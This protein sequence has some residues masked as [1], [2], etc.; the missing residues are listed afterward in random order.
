MCQNIYNYDIEHYYIFS[1]Q[2]S[3]K[4][5]CKWKATQLE[6]SRGFQ[7]LRL[8]VSVLILKINTLRSFKPLVAVFL[9]VS[10]ITSVYGQLLTY[11]LF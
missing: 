7:A 5:T 2:T 9:L 10:T 1:P 11:M 6:N 8:L 4:Q 3:T